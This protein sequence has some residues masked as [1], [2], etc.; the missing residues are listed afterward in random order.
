MNDPLK[1]KRMARLGNIISIIG[2]INCIIWVVLFLFY[3]EHANP[4]LLLIG[5]PATILGAVVYDLAKIIRW[6]KKKQ[7]E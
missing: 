2:V 3:N 7:G 4:F 1:L 6:F 5:A